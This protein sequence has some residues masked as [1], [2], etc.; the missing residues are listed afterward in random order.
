MAGYSKI[1]VVPS[2]NLDHSNK[3]AKKAKKLHGYV[4][5]AVKDEDGNDASLK[6]TWEAKP[7][8]KVKCMADFNDQSWVVWNQGFENKNQSETP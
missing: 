4:S 5:D 8:E 1:T 7:P 3:S 6:I 2:V